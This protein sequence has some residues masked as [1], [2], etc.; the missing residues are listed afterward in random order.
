MTMSAVLVGFSIVGFVGTQGVAQ[1]AGP[2]PAGTI[3]VSDESTNSIDVFAGTNGD[4]APIR[5]ISGSN[6]GIT[7]PIGPDDVKVNAAGDIFSSNFNSDS[8]TEYA[9]GASGNV[10]PICTIA[11][12]NTGLAENDDISL[13]SDGTLYVGNFVGSDP[14]EVFAPGACGNVAPIRVIAGTLTGLSLVDGLGVD[15]AGNLYV[16][17][18]FS[19]SVEVFAPGANGNVAPIRT[20]AG[21]TTGIGSPDDVVVGFN[22]EIYVTNGFGGGVNGVLVFAP[23]AN[24]NVAPIQNISGSNTDFG[25]PDDLAVDASGNIYVTDEHSSLGPA[26]LEYASGA[27]GNVAPIASITGPTTTL[28]GPEGVAVAGTPMTASASL[29]SNVSSSSIT[30]G[31]STHDTAA[32]SGGTS[33]TGSLI[34]KLFGP[35]DPTCSAA[36]AYTSPLTTVTGD[37]NYTSPSFVPTKAGTYSWVD[38]YSGDTHNAPVSTACGDPDETVTVSGSTTHTDTVVLNFGSAPTYGPQSP[39]APGTNESLSAVVEPNGVKNPGSGVTAPTGTITFFDG[40][41]Q[42]AKVSTNAYEGSAYAGDFTN[43]LALGSHEITAVYSGDSNY[44]TVTSNQVQITVATGA[45]PTATATPTTVGLN[46]GS[47][48]AYTEQSPVPGGNNEVFSATVTANGVVN[49]GTVV[50]PTGTVSFF[51]GTTLLGKVTLST[52]LGSSHATLSTKALPAG[53]DEITAVYNGDSKHPASTSNQ[54][55]VTVS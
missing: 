42:I 51:D 14:V 53:S 39:V 23:G 37:G 6:T 47:A 28:V 49:S 55:Q 24:G 36:P 31:S 2:D 16:D 12:S 33:P 52:Y 30:L 11:G 46:F 8:I 13:A 44:P 1:A 32:L 10:A 40:A 43:K 34:F 7:G 22:G 15:A 35:G 18:T 19:G 5:T 25:N 45:K 54:V 9:P 20:I 17:N 26:V 41:T 48:P 3:Y 27:N 21:A 29:T 4:V 50:A 38:L